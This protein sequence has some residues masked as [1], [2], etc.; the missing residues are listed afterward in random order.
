MSEKK[1]D[2]AELARRRANQRRQVARRL[3]MQALY[4]WQL[5]DASAKSIQ[6]EFRAD[7]D[8]RKADSDYF[9]RII[10]LAI[11]EI[12]EL[13]TALSAHLTRQFDLV[14]PVERAIL[15]VASVELKHH[16]EVPYR[17]VINEAISLTKKYGAKD[18][19]KFV[20]GVLD[21]V[22]KEYRVLELKAQ[23]PKS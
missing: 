15:L 22:C 4:Q 7:E 3:A 9:D 23:K 18:S 10:S 5:N 2:G 12:A 19:H 6:V 17:V 21:K 8:F 13:G 16:F 1:N 14:D 20:N 11:A